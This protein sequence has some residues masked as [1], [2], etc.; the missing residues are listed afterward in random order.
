MIFIY[1]LSDGEIY[2]CGIGWKTLEEFYGK[3]A[4]EMSKIFGSLY[5]PY[6]RY[7]YDNHFKFKVDIDSKQLM[8]VDIPDYI[9]NM[10]ERS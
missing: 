4:E 5:L 2:Q 9:K 6:D 10:K 1:Y 3:R 7:V 8:M